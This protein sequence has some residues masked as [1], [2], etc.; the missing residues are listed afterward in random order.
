MT[1]VRPG[2]LY[3]ASPHFMQ[4]QASCELIKN[5][6]ESDVAR[7]KATLLQIINDL[8]SVQFS[9]NAGQDTEPA[10]DGIDMKQLVGN[11]DHFAES[12]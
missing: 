1:I 12:G 5:V 9:A 8:V 4:D 3:R 2:Y 6:F 7:P 10:S 11:N